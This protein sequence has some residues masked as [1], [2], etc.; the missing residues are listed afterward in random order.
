METASVETSAT[1][2]T[3]RGPKSQ[4][5]EILAAIKLLDQLDEDD[6]PASPKERQVLAKFG[7]F[8]QVALTLFPDPVTANYK[9]SDWQTLGEELQSLLSPEDYASAKR[10]T[11][12]AFYTSPIVMTAMHRAL[13][14]L[15]VPE[16]GLLLEPGCGIGNF[17]GAAPKSQRFIGVELDRTSG[18]IAR[19]LYPEQDIRIESFANTKIPGHALDAVIGN[20]P[21][22][23]LKLNYRGERFSLH[24]YFCA[25]SIDLLKPGGIMAVV[26]THYGLDKVNASFREY[27]ADR[28]NFLGAIRLPS[29]A[30]Q[31]QGTAV[32]TDILFLEKRVPGTEPEHVD[33]EWLLTAPL[34]IDGV[35]ISINRYFHNHPEM[36]LG[37][38]SR[39][40]TLYGGDS[41]YSL[42]SNGD[43]A[44][45]LEQA[46]TRLPQREHRTV[47]GENEQTVTEFARPPPTPNLSEGS[48]FIAEDQTICQVQ[49]GVSVP[50]KHGQNSLM[51]NGTLM[52]QRIAGLIA[53]RDAARTVLK[54]Q[55]E[56]WP[57]SE[58]E[59]AR[60][61]LNNV[62]DRFR[63]RYGPINKTTFGET[64]Q[65]TTIRRMPNLVKFRDDPDAMLVMSLEEYDE[66]TGQASKAAI[67]Q[68]DVVGRIQPV[69][70]VTTAEDGLLVSLDRTGQID[71]ELIA[72]L[73][74]HPPEQIV[75]ELGSLIYHDP[76]TEQW[77]TADVYLSGNV[78]SKL[79][80]AQQ[81]GPD[82]ERNAAALQSVQP[83]DV[84]PGEID[85]KIGSPFIPASD[86]SAFASQLFGVADDLIQVTHLAKDAYWSVSARYEAE[87]SV[88][89][90]TE[91]GT[92]RANG[93]WLLDLA[94]NMKTPVIYDRIELDGNEVRVVNQEETLAAREKQKQIK[95]KFKDW[96]FTDPER[97]ERLVRLYNE[98][99]NN[100]RLRQFDGSHLA[101]PGMNQAIQ[102]RPHQTAAVWRAMS[103]G[104]TLLAHTVGAGKTFTMAATGMKLK[105]A[106]LIHKP[107]YVVPN[108]MLE[109]FSREF[110]QLYPN[111]QLLVTAKDDL[112]KD[113][114]KR[115]TAQ[116]ATGQWDGIIVTHSSFER[117]GMSSEFQQRFLREQI[118]DYE[119]LLQDAAIEQAGNSSKSSRNLIKTIE[120]Q[121]AQHEAKLQELL[122]ADKKDDGLVFD[123]LGVDH[124][125]IDEAH[126]FKN[127]ETPTKMDRVAGLQTGGSQRAF[128]LFLKSR[129]LDEL[130]PGHG[131]TFATGTPISNTMVEMYTL[132]RLLDP[133]GLAA[134][135]IE[136]FDAWAA[137]FGEV[138]DTM[139]I[140][141]DGMSL[142]PRSRFAKFNNLPELQQ[143]FRAFADVQTAEMLDLP[144]P[145]LKGGKAEIVACPMSDEQQDLQ[146][147]LVERYT[148]IRSERIDPREDNALAI[149]T[150]GRKL[151]LDARM[152]SPQAE[153]FEAS[154]VQ[155]LVE[156]IVRIWDE[157]Q[158]RRSTQI[159]FCDLG[160]QPTVWGYS[161]YDEIIA[162]LIERGIPR[163]EIAAVGDADSDAKKQALFERV[164]SG[165]IRVLLGSTLKMGTGTNVQQRL[166]ALHHL[167]AP[168]KP[169]EVE[170]REGRI[171]RQGNQNLEVEIYRY[172]TEGSFDAYMWQALE[173]KARFISQVIS[174]ATT[175]R[176][177]EDIGGQEIS[178]AEVKAI[179]SGNPAV[180]TL[181]EADAELQR[182]AVLK[183]NHQDEQFLTRRM[184]KDLPEKIQRLEQS[185]TDLKADQST[186][187]SHAEAPIIIGTQQSSGRKSAFELLGS[188]LESAPTKVYQKTDLPLGTY[189]GCRFGLT[190][191]PSF[192]PE[193]YLAG[194]TI[195]GIQ[196]SQE[197]SGPRAIFNALD[198]LVD[199][200]D[201]RIQDATE[202]L[203][204]SREQLADYQARI[205]R[206]F[207]H[208]AYLTEL[209][210]LRDQLKES[211]SK[212]HPSEDEPTSAEIADQI[213]TRIGSTTV[214]P[215]A[216]L[217]AQTT[218]ST[219]E[220][221]TQQIQRRRGDSENTPKEADSSDLDM[222]KDLPYRE[223]GKDET[224]FANRLEI[225]EKTKTMSQKPV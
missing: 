11:F 81:T 165:S 18:R 104:N 159:V 192:R 204:L 224:G 46:L 111:A 110:M 22:A 10:T 144:R 55:N 37:A 71:L 26:T 190:L 136:H 107:L 95:E 79:I 67:L 158:D 30:F 119:Q 50:V 173:T 75:S 145:K 187:Q 91:Y 137:T 66:V 5:R 210:Q 106:G 99:Y 174:G 87:H 222:H 72:E 157:T 109:Q 177:A 126:F 184:V 170:Q 140:S 49:E 115:L 150:D 43:L 181:A 6:R 68:Q 163:Q 160:I 76:E 88:A 195:S 123:E 113:R 4:A 102:L 36:V 130:H 141:P 35:E 122:S 105:Q 98:T 8:G 185:L 138:V 175:V 205:D 41:G 179:A 47:A 80:T 199:R 58:R 114:R 93:I 171:L 34:E 28:A 148:R 155:A 217:D 162:K 53:L 134:R 57:E 191:Y 156:N 48:F 29:D 135:G 7:G 94:L 86:I 108:H 206:K 27:L 45:Q 188:A 208:D 15:G 69:T 117:I 215:A 147:E 90:T 143:M 83:P 164:R 214:Q 103:S 168:W 51:A 133:R 92:L 61:A 1:G 65:G 9:D 73:Y 89:A 3:G 82:Y 202:D 127:L 21:F 176:Q 56:G 39:Q 97:T 149:T 189:Q 31:Q 154:K 78:R 172:V 129:Y 194:A 20:V 221:I 25:K 139:E 200:I 207:Q 40:D 198:K 132:Q 17:I 124:V 14:R 19:R 212:D 120:K 33:P 63:S 182:L 128:D 225:E 62:Y 118:S 24:D 146:L 32:V 116:I 167:D 152:L 201:R 70:Q 197:N 101:F 74:G 178:F 161:V 112:R 60:V 59:S 125:F 52:G 42:K 64:K 77:E 151:A 84:L 218:R 142:R 180:L 216:R 186:L 13:T 203:T 12:N 183:K 166:I 213:K 131:V 153:A 196:M 223:P 85:A 121:K 209:T 54:S 38:W 219:E 96:V 100:I 169:A 220:A 23:N 16:Q 193:L 211:L 44:R 2:T